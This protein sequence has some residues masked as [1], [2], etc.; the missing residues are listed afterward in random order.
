MDQDLVPGSPPTTSCAPFWSRQRDNPPA[1]RT[2]NR[3]VLGNIAAEVANI[4][5]VDRQDSLQGLRRCQT[6]ATTTE[7][8][9]IEDLLRTQ[10]EPA[11]GQELVEKILRDFCSS[12]TYEEDEDLPTCESPPWFRFRKK[13][14]RTYARRKRAPSLRN[15]SSVAIEVDDDEEEDDRLSC[16]SGLSVQE[17]HTA[18][19]ATTVC[20]LDANTSQKICENLLNLSEYFSLSNPTSNCNQNKDQPQVVSTEIDLPTKV[21]P[22]PPKSSSSR[23]QRSHLSDTNSSAECNS[24]E[25]ETL[26]SDLLQ[27]G[28][29]FEAS[30]ICDIKPRDLLDLCLCMVKLINIF[31]IFT[32]SKICENWSEGD[33]LLENYNTEK[34][35]LSDEELAEKP[36]L[37]DPVK[38]EPKESE[39][40]LTQSLLDDIPISEWQTPM[41]IPEES[42]EKSPELSPEVKI[43]SSGDKTQETVT[44]S[45]SKHIKFVGFR[46]ASNKAIEITEEMANRGAMFIAQ[47]KA[48]DQ[49]SQS[50]D[51]EFLQGIAFSEWQ[52][53]DL[54]ENPTKLPERENLSLSINRNH[55]EPPETK[56][57]NKSQSMNIPQL[58]AFRKTP[59]KFME[60]TEEMKI[61]GD[62][63]MAEVESG[64]YQPSQR[65]YL[66]NPEVLPVKES[67][68]PNKVSEE[69]NIKA[70]EGIEF[71]GFRTA[72][73]KPIVVSDE[74]KIK[75]KQF[76][77]EFQTRGGL[78]Q[79]H[80]AVALKNTDFIDK[81]L[82]V[83]EETKRRGMDASSSNQQKAEA[84]GSTNSDA[85][86][87]GF[88]T[89]S[90]KNIV[91]SKAMKAKA[92]LFMAEFQV[93]S[94]QNLNLNPENKPCD[95]DD[96][97]EF[98]G[99]RTASNKRIEISEEMKNKAAKLMALVQAESEV[100]PNQKPTSDNECLSDISD[101]VSDSEDDSKVSTPKQRRETY[102]GIPSG[103]RLRKI[104]NSSPE[105]NCQQG[106]RKLHKTI[107]CHSALGTPIQS[108]E[109]HASLSQL[110]GRSP[111]DQKTKT[112]V[113][114]RRNLLTLSKRRKRS[115]TPTGTPLKSRLAAMPAST[116]TPLADRNTNHVQDLAAT[117]TTAEDMSPICMPPNKS[118]RLGLSRS[119]Y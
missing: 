58:V 30:E 54:P 53:I 59:Y 52:P 117:K 26:E 17:D 25:L 118:R 68:R 10:A 21:A 2:E 8:I 76:M 7:F 75:A 39:A 13:K 90:N 60:V 32:D 109:I 1:M 91:I 78:D 119:R 37:I 22:E 40:Q 57:P 79:E 15:V 64:L 47:F 100:N 12:P 28:F 70:A 105:Q 102:E 83:S 27:I 63:L 92:A 93:E 29:T 69:L 112:S 14:I 107:S 43:Q 34:M 85:D 98:S 31:R 110:A 4:Y 115:R 96:A 23:D 113:I 66:Q 97:P 80:E 6:V 45:T 94:P 5:N 89:A 56:T 48:S 20:E 114:A 116:S 86:F 24:I 84:T 65:R 18:P 67:P 55:V 16:S 82:V 73:D 88:R 42:I 35:S 103:K 104:S 111:L 38:T 101:N 87:V 9:S 49:L 95:S 44:A 106:S 41:G 33:S 19:T 74:M 51:A 108:Q 61:K 3:E 11:P 62:K 77:A 72:S 71:V 50:N 46:T 36:L 99:F 81:P